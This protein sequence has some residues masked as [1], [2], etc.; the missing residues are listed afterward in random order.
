VP[1]GKGT[2]EDVK[3]QNVVLVGAE[4][5]I[6]ITTHYFCEQNKNCN[7]DVSLNIKNVVI[8]NISG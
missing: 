4:N 7:N 1:G 2:V 3:F 6:A 8:D 5:P